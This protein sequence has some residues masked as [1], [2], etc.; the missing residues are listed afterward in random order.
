MNVDPTK[1]TEDS[2]E[3]GFIAQLTDY[4]VSAEELQEIEAATGQKILKEPSYS[5]TD[6]EAG[7]FREKYGENYAEGSVSD[8]FYELAEKG[9]ISQSDALNSTCSGVVRSIEITVIGEPSG[10]N[11][12]KWAATHKFQTKVGPVRYSKHR[13]IFPEE[14][15][16]FKHGYTNDTI[17]WEDYI[18]EQ[19][20]FYEHMRN[21]NM[22]YDDEGNQCPNEPSV[23]YDERLE[24]L[25][26]AAEIIKRIFG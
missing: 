25:E 8:L 6:E 26:R 12:I 9:I 24:G 1:N 18:Q 23:G 15:K 3:K 7:Y 16:E 20:D 13:D 11:S 5:V 17:T 2:S 22:I 4:A 21:R 14:Y 10:A 19:R